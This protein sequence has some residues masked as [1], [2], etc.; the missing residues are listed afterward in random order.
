MKLLDLT[1]PTTPTQPSP[2]TLKQHRSYPATPTTP[3][4]PSHRKK[5]SQKHVRH[6]LCLLAQQESTFLE[7]SIIHAEN[8]TMALAKQNQLCPKCIS[9][10]ANHQLPLQHTIPGN[11]THAPL[12]KTSPGAHTVQSNRPRLPS[13]PT[14]QSALQQRNK[15]AF[16]T[17]STMR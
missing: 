13:P 2:H 17:N 14:K 1:I 11:K 4:H 10:D 5:P 7:L 6:T 16:S 8:E 12:P 9:I 3:L 15:Y